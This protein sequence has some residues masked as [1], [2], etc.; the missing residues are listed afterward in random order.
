MLNR[1]SFI[2]PF[3]VPGISYCTCNYYPEKFSDS[4]F[5]HY[6]IQQPIQL[7]K[8]EPAKKSEF[9]AGTYCARLALINMI[10]KDDL[11][12][13]VPLKINRDL[14]PKWPRGVIGSTA[15][16]GDTAVAVTA[17]A[18]NYL[19]I[20][21]NCQT[22]LKTPAA[23]CMEEHILRKD[24]RSSYAMSLLSIEFFV[25]LALSAKKS[26]SKAMQLPKHKT[27]DFHDIQI[28]KI[29]AD[30]LTL[31]LQKTLNNSWKV[32]SN[33]DVLHK[34]HNNRIFTMAYLAG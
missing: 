26:L 8:A 6:G 27:L 4:A 24:E 30:S 23:L 5:D 29:K 14:S 2:S 15:H 12:I 20:G 31:T 1:F 34:K 33:F 9:L 19:G 21:I 3:S 32:G 16:C 18:D 17:K 11:A 25:T 7:S 13:N 28:K 10:N 22:L